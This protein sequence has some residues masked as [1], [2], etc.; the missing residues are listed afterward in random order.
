MTAIDPIR[1]T[2][3]NVTAVPTAPTVVAC[4]S[5]FDHFFPACGFTD[6]KSDAVSENSPSPALSLLT[7]LVAGLTP[8]ERAA[9]AR[10]LVGSGE[11]G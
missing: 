8:A 7:K 1:L 9:L 4:Y 6:L 10:I 3:S 2:D 5:V 11:G